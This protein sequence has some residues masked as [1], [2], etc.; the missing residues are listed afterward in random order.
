MTLRSVI[1]DVF[2]QAE[3]RPSSTAIVAPDRTLTYQELRS[4]IEAQASSIVAE[5]IIHGDRIVVE[6]TSTSGFC[7]AYFA[8]QLA[9]AVCVPVP[10]NDRA[11][12][13][14]S[15]RDLIDPAMVLT[16]SE[17]ESN[18]LQTPTKDFEF[19]SL[20][21]VAEVM[22]TTGSTGAPKG[23]VLTHRNIAASARNITEF[24]RTDESDREVLPL[25]LSHSFGLGR[26]RSCLTSGAQV[27]LVDGFR[28]PGRVVQ[29]I[30]SSSATG[31]ASVPAGFALLLKLF[32]DDLGV[33]GSGLK[34]VEIGSAP[35][36]L[37]QKERLV[38]LLPSTRICMHYGLTEASRSAFMEFHADSDQLQTAGRA[39]PN[40]ELSVLSDSGTQLRGREV[41]Q[42]AVR[43]DHVAQ[44]YWNDSELFESMQM[45][46]WL[47]TGD[48]GSLDAAGNLQLLGRTDD[49][50]NVGG[51]KIAPQKVED[52][53]IMM[54]GISEAACVGVDDRSQ[55]TGQVI[56][57]Y[58]VAELGTKLTDIDILGFLSD[59]LAPQ[60]LP[61]KFEWLQDLP[62]T[63]SGKIQR[64]LLTQV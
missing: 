53:L 61:S 3:R 5:G 17:Y 52:A 31:F 62:R 13:I 60:E 19:P 11:T 48:T 23:V 30:K 24:V 64:S 51:L 29:A 49:V 38:R 18:R 44:D 35:M 55:V 56:K 28:L 21:D 2:E 14:E 26:L 34:Y 33:I 20:D 50:I 40:V 59:R 25:P 9:G 1:Q 27:N 57:A 63:S 32:G 39:A 43:G 41:G 58:L 8:I 47:L 54:P 16:S 37:D 10:T 12:N 6:A 42:I 36:S 4:A 22:L 46:G 45:G 7:V 15:V